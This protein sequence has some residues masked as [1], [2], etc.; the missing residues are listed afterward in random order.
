MTTSKPHHNNYNRH[1]LQYYYNIKLYCIPNHRSSSHV[2]IHIIMDKAYYVYANKVNTITASCML[3]IC[4]YP[5]LKRIHYLFLFRFSDS[6]FGVLNH[7]VSASTIIHCTQH[8]NTGDITNTNNTIDMW[9][10]T[11]KW[12]SSYLFVSRSWFG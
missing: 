12:K 1:N 8:C 10:D 5:C 7:F 3:L 6:D 4:A 2:Y 9:F 11:F